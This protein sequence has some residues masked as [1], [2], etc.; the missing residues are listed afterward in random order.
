[1]RVFIWTAHPGNDSFTQALAG[2]YRQGAIEQ[3][4]EVRTQELNQMKFDT[5]SFG[6]Y[7]NDMPAL[8]PDLVSFQENLLWCDHFVM[9]HPIWWGMMPA[10]AKAVF[11]RTILSGVAFRFENGKLEGLL[12]GTTAELILT[13]DTPGWLN[14][15]YYRRAYESILKKQ[16]LG[17]CGI[18]T[19]NIHRVGP[20]HNSTQFQRESW[21]TEANRWG[22]TLDSYCL[23]R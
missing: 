17:F 12:S 13:S 15:L 8:E 20:I 2:S 4:A 22:R 3:G 21:L 9:A 19:Q 14:N 7:G 16:I 11:D 10:Q 23:C 18:K 5:S 1:M 6:G